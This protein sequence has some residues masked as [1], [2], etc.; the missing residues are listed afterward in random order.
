MRAEHAG[1]EKLRR[2]K[3]LSQHGHERNRSADA[4]RHALAT[5]ASLRGF[6]QG[7]IEPRL[8]VFQSTDAPINVGA[9]VEALQG[10]IGKFPMRDIEDVAVVHHI[11]DKARSRRCFASWRPLAQSRAKEDG[12]PGVGVAHP[13]I[14]GQYAQKLGCIDHLVEQGLQHR[15]AHDDGFFGLE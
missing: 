7:A 9:E 1:N 12:L 5:E 15:P 10:R 3:P 4:H 11:S 2:R 6:L 8:E 14:E 13:F